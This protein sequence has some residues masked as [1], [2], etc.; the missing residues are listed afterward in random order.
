MRVYAARHDMT[1][2]IGR[3][4]EDDWLAIISNRNG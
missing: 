1:A 4:P 3:R 2:R